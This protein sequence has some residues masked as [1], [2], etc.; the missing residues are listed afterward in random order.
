MNEPARKNPRS[1]RFA[2]SS[3]LPAWYETWMQ[4]EQTSTH[5][6]RF[7]RVDRRDLVYLKFI[8]EAYEGL[9]VMTT[10]EREKA[11]VRIRT[12]P[13][14]AE[15]IDRLVTALR[16]EIVIEETEPPEG[17]GDSGGTDA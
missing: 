12:F 2:L 10:A 7:L 4:Q 14:F 1:R 3:S 5:V 15:E 13:W 9:S 8:L 16:S 6:D 11:V 17:W